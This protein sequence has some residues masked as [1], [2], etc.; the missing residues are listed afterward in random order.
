[1]TLDLRPV[2]APRSVAIVGASE[3]S[4]IA[5]VA[6][7]NCRTVGFSGNVYP[8][9][10]RHDAVLGLPCYAGL[11]ALPEVPDCALIALNAERAVGAIEE[12]CALGVRAVI[13]P[14][15]GFAEAGPEGAERQRRLAAA[16]RASGTLVVGPNCMGVLSP[17][18]RAAVYIGTIARPL[19]PSNLSAVAQSGSV[20]ELLVNSGHLDF[21]RVFSAGNEA[22]LTA[23]DY[24]EYLLDDDATEVIMIYLEAYR[25]PQRLLALAERALE[26]GKPLVAVA[27][28]R[29]SQ[30]QAMAQAHSGALA[31]SYRRLSA[32]LR[33][34]GVLLCD[35]LDEWLATAQLCARGRFPRSNAI[36]AVT[37][38][39]GEGGLLLDLAESCGVRF[40]ALSEAAQRELG[41]RFPSLHRWPN[42]ADG[43]DKGPYEEVYP[44]LLAAL[45]AEPTIDTLVA[46][47]DVPAAQGDE[48]VRYTS[49]IGRH[50]A[51]QAARSGKP[52]VYLS[53]AGGALDERVRAA[54]SEHG[55]LLLGGA[56]PG[57]R[58]I[59]HLAA[60]AALRA[61][62]APPDP[63]PPDFPDRSL[64]DLVA[65]LPVGPAD[66]VASRRL[67]EAAGLPLAPAV[68][69]SNV[70]AAVEAAARFA[71][72]AVLKAVLPGLAHK[73][74]LGAV[75]VR[76]SSPE[77][78]RAQAAR[79]LALCDERG[80]PRRLLVSPY[81]DPAAEVICG[82][83]GD[84]QWGPFVVLGLGGVLAEALD[85]V[86]IVSAPLR[87]GQAESLLSAGSL[88][89]VLSSPRRPADLAALGALVRR[90]SGLAVALWRLDPT[91]A[92]DLNPVMVL[93]PGQGAWAVDAL[94]TRG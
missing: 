71:G 30:A 69:V 11:D 40:P 82:L 79:L 61:E 10:P 81:L 70:T 1:M 28:G 72:P 64:A 6:I 46:A 60:L 31:T 15:G 67:L 55:M 4:F 65:A 9:H 90:L 8:I 51:E 20:V 21:A 47:I 86:T 62:R 94:V 74:D 42:P 93:P 14:A 17:P 54:L 59:A 73:S 12:A 26:R 13:I 87:A 89:R 38:S 16:A 23:C 66:E 18:D 29:S 19:R 75:A 68:E 83:S 53:L 22:L 91:I 92:V 37:V 24:L 41:A 44:P 35:D 3:R 84:P 49:F 57:L 39:G 36:G 80:V 5:R 27:L 76:L 56:R 25:Q 43:W 63:L 34:R 85:E 50:L 2:L 77:Q 45:A 32:A 52:A 88:G 58:A 7:E 48:E 33:Q 78:V